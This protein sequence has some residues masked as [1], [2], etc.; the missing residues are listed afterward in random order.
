MKKMRNSSRLLHP[1]QTFEKKNILIF[2]IAN[3][4]YYYHP[5]KLIFDVRPLLL[6]QFSFN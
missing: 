5:E 4:H 2:V 6:Y 1:N 3:F